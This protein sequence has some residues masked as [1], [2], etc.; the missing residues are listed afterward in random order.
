[1]TIANLRLTNNCLT[2][3][4]TENILSSPSPQPV[5]VSQPQTEIVPV[6]VKTQSTSPST[7]INCD[8]NYI[9]NGNFDSPKLNTKWEVVKTLPG[10][11]SD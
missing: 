2:K 11:S 10:W 6:S 1:M 5:L 9:V 4:I 8:A 7:S 3:T